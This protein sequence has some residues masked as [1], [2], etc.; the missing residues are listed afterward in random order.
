MVLAALLRRKLLGD[1][2]QA[3]SAV[4]M[5]RPASEATPVGGRPLFAAVDPSAP[6]CAYADASDERLRSTR[7]F[8]G[9]RKDGRLSI[10]QDFKSGGDT[11]LATALESRRLGPAQVDASAP[12][13]ATWAKR[14]FVHLAA[15]VLCAMTAATS[16]FAQDK[17]LIRYGYILPPVAEM[18]GI[19]TVK[20]EL[21]KHHGKTY[22]FEAKF[23]RGSPL[24]V[25]A[26]AA[27]EI[28]LGNLGVSTFHQAVVNAGLSDM[29]IIGD[30]AEDGFSGMFAS[31]IRVRKDSGINKI[32]DLK[33]KVIATIA[34]GSGADMITRYT[35]RKHGLELNKDYTYLETPFPTM[36]AMLLEKKV[37]AAYFAQ[38][39]ATDPDVVAQTSVLFTTA[40]SMGPL[41][42]NFIAG[43]GTFFAKHRAAMVD[44]MEDFI[45]VV[46]W[47]YDPANR[48][49]SIKIVSEASKVPEAVLRRYIFSNAD[50]FR[51]L[52]AM[53]DLTVIQKNWAAM[54]EIGLIRQELK[55]NDYSDLSIVK[56]AAGRLGK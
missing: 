29:K 51:S 6:D 50:N 32:A 4:Q 45:R 56:E 13:C 27:G 19:F 1:Q 2:H 26:L 36:K 44:F 34:L 9:R 20:P 23:L 31:Q 41:M 35:L 40:D 33:G 8:H 46:R 48:D 16:A 52:D 11:M 21:L 53:P 28:E 10:K 39:F 17:P 38:P 22:N 5:Q 15:A 18:A 7:F 25:T 3:A 30:E 49:E 42:L 14:I 43:R 37:D 55:V 24:I 47:Y 54:K 12:E